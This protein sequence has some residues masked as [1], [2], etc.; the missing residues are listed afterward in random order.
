MTAAGLNSKYVIYS[1]KFKYFISQPYQAAHLRFVKTALGGKDV[2]AQGRP[3]AVIFS[4]DIEKE[5]GEDVVWFFSHVFRNLHSK[6]KGKQVYVNHGVSFKNWINEQKVEALNNHFDVIFG[7]AVIQERVFIQAGVKKEKIKP[8]VYPILF[9]IPEI[10]IRPN[11][12]LFSSTCYS[13]W[14]HYRNLY[15]ILKNLHPSIDGYLTMHSDTSEVLRAMLSSACEGKKNIRILETQ[16]ELLESYA[17]CQCVVGGSGSVC[18]PFWF[19][20]KPVIF[21][22]GGEGWNLFKRFGWSE[23]KKEIIDP[24]FHQLLDESTKISHWAQF[25]PRLVKKAKVAPSARDLFYPSSHDREWTINRIK[26]CIS[27]LSGTHANG[28]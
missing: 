11:S 27:E 6:L 4:E 28:A 13:H 5:D 17:Y 24:A 25:S 12:V 19:L 2:V 3:H 1:M 16:E 20:K 9:D 14:N 18:A 22:K 26:Q 21:L 10:P 23:I 15:Q 8:I 7:G